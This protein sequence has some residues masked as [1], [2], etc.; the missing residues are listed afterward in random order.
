MIPE[1]ITDHTIL[2]HPEHVFGGVFIPVFRV[3]PGF[4]LQPVVQFGEGVA[5]ILQVNQ[6]LRPYPERTCWWKPGAATTMRART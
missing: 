3:D 2:G 5:D 4:G 1:G 6:A